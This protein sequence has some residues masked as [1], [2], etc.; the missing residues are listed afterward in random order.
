MDPVSHSPYF[1]LVTLLIKAFTFYP[2]GQLEYV[3]AFSTEPTLSGIRTRTTRIRAGFLYRTNSL[4][5]KN[6]DNWNT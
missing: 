6:K 1:L 5:Y 2:V 3:P 4:W